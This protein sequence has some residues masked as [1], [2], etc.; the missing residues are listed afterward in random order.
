MPLRNCKQKPGENIHVFA[1][2][3]LSLAE[4]AYN[5]QG[6]EAIERQLIDI[7]VGGL[8]NDQ[9]K[10]KILQ[11]AIGVAANEQNLRARVN[12]SHRT[13]EPM[14]VDHSRGQRFRPRNRFNR[15]STVNDRS[16]RPIR[17]LHCG[18]EGHVIRE[19]KVKEQGNR[20]AMGHSRSRTNEARRP[21]SQEN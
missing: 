12:M 15:V 11:A 19:Y 4:D 6:G 18:Q 16:N 8:M 9:L 2:R 20:P 21:G 3:L 13:S 1:E 5:N 10:L 14:E 17:C 7:F